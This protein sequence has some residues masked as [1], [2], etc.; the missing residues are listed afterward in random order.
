MKSAY[1]NKVCLI[2]GFH[3]EVP[4]NC[5]VLGYYIASSGNLLLTFCD[6]L[7]VQSSGLKNPN[8]FGFLNPKDGTD[9][10]SRN[11]SKKL[12]LLAAL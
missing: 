4:E 10:L 1:Q 2:S 12:P 7:L 3:C 6:S 5:A 8:P 11:I 9:R